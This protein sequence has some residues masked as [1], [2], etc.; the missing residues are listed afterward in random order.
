MPD[1]FTRLPWHAGGLFFMVTVYFG[2]PAGRFRHP[3]DFL[4]ALGR[5]AAQEGQGRLVDIDC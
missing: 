4:V 3:E 1:Y 2:V 5:R